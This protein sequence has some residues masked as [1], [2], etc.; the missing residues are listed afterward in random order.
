MQEVVGW[1]SQRKHSNT[2]VMAGKNVGLRDVFFHLCLDRN[3]RFD[4]Q[5]VDVSPQRRD[6]HAHL[7]Q[8]F[9]ESLQAP[10]ASRPAPTPALAIRRQK[11]SC[12]RGSPLSLAYTAVF[13][14]RSAGACC[15]GSRDPTARPSCDRDGPSGGTVGWGGERATGDGTGVLGRTV[16]G[17]CN[18]RRGGLVVGYV[19]FAF[20][21]I[22]SAKKQR[23]VRGGRGN[24]CRETGGMWWRSREYFQRRF[25]RR[26]LLRRKEMV[27][28]E[29]SLTRDGAHS[30]LTTL[31][32]Q[33]V[34][35]KSL[36]QLL[37]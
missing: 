24:W 33:I 3:E 15:D 18:S 34:R 32:E 11:A 30:H 14:T 2:A 19:F 36:A 13:C 22:A 31:S 27:I 9:P 8:P 16:R 21:V 7:Y 29:M 6:I 26:A 25:V 10:L 37:L 4:A 23:L 17:K 20:V 1:L 28:Y 35:K 5:V 12:S